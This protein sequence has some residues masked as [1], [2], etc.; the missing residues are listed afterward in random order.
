MSSQIE[1]KSDKTRGKE[2]VEGSDGRLNTSSRSDERA[3]YNSRDEEQCY[4]VPFDFQN[5]TAGEF[6]VYWKNTNTNDKELV[7][8]SIGINSVE[9]SRI[10]LW[11]VSG[12]AAGGTSI[13]PTNLNRH[14]SNSASASA[15]EGGSGATGIT[16]VTGESL[17]DFLYVS[18]AGHE[19]FRLSDR[20]RLGQNDAIALEYNEGTTGDFSGVIFGYYE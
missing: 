8:S 9:A 14:S 2:D 11:F 5:A 6:G 13:V 3:Y 18:A 20:I 17:I 16:G 4:T 1:Y 12:T 19:E 10:K 15:M 7:I